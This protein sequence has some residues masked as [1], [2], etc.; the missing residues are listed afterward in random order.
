MDDLIKDEVNPITLIE[1]KNV[2]K[3]SKTKS[4][5]KKKEK[6]I[7]NDKECNNTKEKLNENAIL[8]E[9]ISEKVFDSSL[10]KEYKEMVTSKIPQVD[11]NYALFN[12]DNDDGLKAVEIKSNINS[13]LNLSIKPKKMSEEQMSNTTRLLKNNEIDLLKNAN[14]NVKS[15]NESGDKK[16]KNKNKKA[17]LS[18]DKTLEEKL[19]RLEKEYKEDNFI[20][21]QTTQNKN[22]TNLNN[23]NNNINYLDGS[24]SLKKLSSQEVAC[25]KSKTEN[26]V[27]SSILKTTS[28]D[29]KCSSDDF[30]NIDFSLGKKIQKDDLDE[31]IL[32][33]KSIL[34][35]TFIKNKPQN[36]PS[37]E[38]TKLGLTNIISNT[39]ISILLILISRL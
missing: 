7:E 12:S 26:Y 30:N 36:E 14:N 21:S 38:N 27:N 8:I 5:K 33:N 32:N 18:K 24:L 39:K 10:L 16:S 34:N 11:S 35:N 23:S 20:S 9:K 25:K 19:E 31:L 29:H 17:S 28:N 37:G 1:D 2:T 3:K 13:N 15:L 6:D 4:K 22:I